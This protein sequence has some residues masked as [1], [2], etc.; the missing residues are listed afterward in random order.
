MGIKYLGIDYVG[1]EV[2][3]LHK[4]HEVKITYIFNIANFVE[5]VDN[6]VNVSALRKSLQICPAYADRV[7]VEEVVPKLPR[8]VRAGP[9][10]CSHDHISTCALGNL[11]LL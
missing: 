4:K 7:I 3:S 5:L 2:R 6:H 10:E 8:D 11:N 1:Y 9:N